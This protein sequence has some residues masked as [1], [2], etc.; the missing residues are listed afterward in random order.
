METPHE[1]KD[2][3]TFE[4][5]S[6]KVIVSDPCYNRDTWCMGDLHHVKNGEWR[7]YLHI[8]DLGDWGNRVGYIRC[9]H[10]DHDCPLIS[11]LGPSWEQQDFEVGVDSGQAGIYDESQYHGGEDDY[12]EGGWYDINC[13]LTTNNEYGGVL[14]GG[15]VSSSGLGDGGYE[16]KVVKSTD[17]KI[18]GILIDFGLEDKEEDNEEEDQ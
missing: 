17:E 2:I 18:V 1:E 10:K 12:G 13:N 11:Q 7:A 16:C 8:F 14:T 3:G 4:I 9:Y 15:V 6:G 5:T